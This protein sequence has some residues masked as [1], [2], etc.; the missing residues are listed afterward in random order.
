MA[1]AVGESAVG[2][3]GRSVG[4]VVGITRTKVGAATNVSAVNTARVGVG[5]VVLA[6]S[7]ANVG[8]GAVASCCMNAANVGGGRSVVVCVVP[9]CFCT[10]VP[11]TS[12]VGC[13][14]GG[15]VAVA[16]RS[17]GTAACAKVIVAGVGVAA[18]GNA[19][20]MVTT[21]PACGRAT[22]SGNLARKSIKPKATRAMTTS[23][24]PAKRP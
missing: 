8:G 11:S 5:C 20:G 13:R 15:C 22:P 3:G 9:R 6:D 21:A 19:A 24:A 12:S 7:F 2:V 14:V 10:V 16:G 17:G 1:V 4:V 23:A 18:A